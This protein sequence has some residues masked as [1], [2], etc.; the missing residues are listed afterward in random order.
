MGSTSPG[1]IIL[2]RHGET[3]ANR[4]RCFAD[5]DEIPL[6]QAGCL[7]AQQLAA[8]LA[9]EFRPAALLS[10]AYLRARQTSEII[11]HALRLTTEVVTGI[12]ERNFGC[13][14]G[15]SYE[16]LDKLMTEE[17]FR[18]PARTR[19]W[20][21][22]GGESLEDVRARV[23]PVIEAIRA[24]FPERQV[25]VVCHGAVIRAICAHIT[26]DWD[27]TRVLANC[28]LTVIDHTPEGWKEPETPINPISGRTIT[29]S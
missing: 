2:V 11:E 3:E 23:V 12:H 14:R 18:D 8:R 15:H 13:L 7:Q 20:R 16:R 28:G 19:L 6:T 5:S 22:E 9:A 17:V 1:K 26:G 25:V 4:R 24:R 10:S 21:P 29:L 27:E